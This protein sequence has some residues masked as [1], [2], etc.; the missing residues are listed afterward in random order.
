[1]KSREK[2]VIVRNKQ[3][4]DENQMNLLEAVLEKSL[5]EAGKSAK[6]NLWDFFVSSC[7][8]FEPPMKWI[9]KIILS[10]Y[11]SWF[12][13]AFCLLR[14]ILRVPF[15]YFFFLFFWFITRLVRQVLVYRNCIILRLKSRC[16]EPR[17]SV[18]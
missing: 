12:F 7:C 11:F 10:S 17:Y 16:L 2:T 6:K 5:G 3:E 4:V 8:Y 1:M 15:F 14:W 9:L 18:V 13:Y